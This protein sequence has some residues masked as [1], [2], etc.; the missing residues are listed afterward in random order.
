MTY[1]NITLNRYETKCCGIE[2]GSPVTCLFEILTCGSKLK[3][4]SSYS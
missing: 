1:I 3:Y 2:A 4:E